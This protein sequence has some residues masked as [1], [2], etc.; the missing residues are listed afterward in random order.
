[1]GLT[2]DALRA[3][4]AEL[5]AA[6]AAAGA[7][8]PPIA[9][10][11]ALPRTDPAAARDMLAAYADAG[12]DAARSTPSATPTADEFRRI[13]DDLGPSVTAPAGE[14][15]AVRLHAGPGRRDGGARSRCR[16]GGRTQ[17]LQ[18]VPHEALDQRARVASTRSRA[19]RVA[20]CHEA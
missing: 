14:S 19:S 5:R 9:V 7:P 15:P 13:L 16:I 17:H 20:S 1:M 12:R 18:H 11:G 6:A 10:L 3:P 4:A 2:P 8:P